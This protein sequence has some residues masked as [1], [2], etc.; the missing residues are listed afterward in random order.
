MAKDTEENITKEV[1]TSITNLLLGCLFCAICVSLIAPF[2]PKLAESKGVN[3]GEQS[4]VFMLPE[5]TG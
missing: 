3:P 1:V 4:F 2:F 5:L